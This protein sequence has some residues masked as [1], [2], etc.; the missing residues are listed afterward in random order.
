M[1]LWMQLLLNGGILQQEADDGTGGGGAGGGS[2]GTGD[3]GDGDNGAGGDGKGNGDGGNGDG[4]SNGAGK[5]KPT[6]KEAELI[7][8]VMKRK[9]RESDLK[10]ELDEMKAKFEGIDPEEVKKIIKERKEQ[11]DADLEARG[12]FE[13]LKQRMADEHKAEVTTLKDKIQELENSRNQRDGEI[14]SLTVGAQ[15]AQSA[16]IGSELTLTASKARQLYSTHFDRVDGEIVGYDKPRGASNRTQLVN[17]AGEALSF[18]DAMRKIIEA[19]PERDALLRSKMKPG[20]GSHSK[21][22][23]PPKQEVKL[24][25]TEKIAAGLKTL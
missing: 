10:T 14:D 12:E 17:S 20:S 1:P 15:F 3:N 11:E 5:P 22:N 19:D 9:Q 24:S 2:P 6:D 7:K 16:F 18:D 21:Q 13:R 8:E 4:G 25:R 23:P